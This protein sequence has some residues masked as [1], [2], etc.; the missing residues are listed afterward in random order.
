M[1]I[2]QHYEWKT[3]ICTYQGLIV[4][5]LQKMYENQG[6]AEFQSQLFEQGGIQYLRKQNF[7]LFQPPTYP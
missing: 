3:Q 6:L 7:D 5:I 1:T 4:H 2:M